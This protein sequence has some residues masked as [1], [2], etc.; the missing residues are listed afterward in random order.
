[1]DDIV[2]QALAKW[3]HVPHCYGWLGLDARGQWYMRDARAQ[4]LGGFA[5]GVPGARGALL[6]HEKLIGFIHRNYDCD[7]RGQW[8]FQNGPQRVYV[9]LEATPWIWRIDFDGQVR[10]HTGIATQP[11]AC[12]TDEA[13]RVYLLTPLGIGLV[14]TLDVP[15]VADAIEQG[16]WQVQSVHAQE[17]PQRF[18]F[19]RQPAEK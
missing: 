16:R 15:A 2:K 14:H 7:V 5:S 4:A 13:G 17:L 1:M 11:S 9:E 8:F 10:S 6:R 19:V 18:G 3:P 12:L